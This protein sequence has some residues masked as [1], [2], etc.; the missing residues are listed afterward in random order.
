MITK[1][2]DFIKY[3]IEGGRDQKKCN[4][5]YIEGNKLFNYNTVIAEVND[6]D[7]ITI[8]MSKYS[9]STTKIQNVLKR[10]ALDNYNNVNILYG[11]DIDS[12]DLINKY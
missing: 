10:E 8:N 4:N 11:V 6:T 7:E 5:L 2:N 12:I 1:N 3:F 9:V